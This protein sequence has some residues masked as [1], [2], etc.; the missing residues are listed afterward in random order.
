MIKLSWW[1]EFVVGTAISF[2]VMLTTKVTN[3]MELEALQTTI[4]VLQK[5]LA[6]QVSLT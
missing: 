1:E 2:L 6:G 3:K 4:G 5:L